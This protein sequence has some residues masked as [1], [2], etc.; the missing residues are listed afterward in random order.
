MNGNDT[1]KRQ[2]QSQIQILKLFNIFEKG[3]RVSAAYHMPN[4]NKQVQSFE[5]ALFGRGMGIT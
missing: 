3:R 4:L 5:L 1:K 2:E